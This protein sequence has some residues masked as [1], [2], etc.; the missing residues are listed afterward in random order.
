MRQFAVALVGGLAISAFRVEVLL[1]QTPKWPDLP[2]ERGQGFYLSWLK[3][4]VCWLLFL[5]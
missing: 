1:A 2:F 4:I 5:V 3:I